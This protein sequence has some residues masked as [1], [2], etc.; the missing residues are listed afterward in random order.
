M[1]E[2]EIARLRVLDL[3]PPGLGSRTQLDGRV[4]RPVRGIQVAPYVERRYAL[5]CR[6]GVEAAGVGLRRQVLDKVE[7]LGL[8]E[9]EE[10]L[11]G[12]RVFEP[13]EPP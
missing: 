5:L 10:V 2:V 12:V 6:H 13:C 3:A 11:D 8:V 9:A 1:H 4:Q 7:R